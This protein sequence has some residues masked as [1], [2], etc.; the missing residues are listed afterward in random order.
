MTRSAAGVH[1]VYRKGE[2]IDDAPE[3]FM[4]SAV[5]TGI[6]EWVVSPEKAEKAKS[7]STTK[8]TKNAGTAKKTTKG[9]K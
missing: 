5:A 8:S 7:S 3:A 1:A 6:A 4:Q 9:K 2:V